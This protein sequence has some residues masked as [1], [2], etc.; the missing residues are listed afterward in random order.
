MWRSALKKYTHKDSTNHGGQASPKDSV[1]W[2]TPSSKVVFHNKLKHGEMENSGK[3]ANKLGK[4]VKEI[5]KMHGLTL[6]ERKT[7]ALEKIAA[8]TQSLV[9]F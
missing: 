2:K 3:S 6:E 5:Q 7:I 9:Q 8:Y 1:I 4:T